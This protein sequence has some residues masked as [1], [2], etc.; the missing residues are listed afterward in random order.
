MDFSQYVMTAS[1]FTATTEGG[2]SA[3]WWVYLVA[4]SAFFLCMFGLQ[5]AAL[6][7]IAKREGYKHKW[8]AF[9]PFVSTYYIGVC[10][11]KNRLFKGLSTKVV[12]LV[13]AIMEAALFACSVVFYV[14]C[15][16]LSAAGSLTLEISA[17]YMPELNLGGVPAYLDWAE[18]CAIYLDQIVYWFDI[19]LSLFEIFLFAAFFQTYGARHYFWFTLLCV[20]FPVQGIIMFVVRKNK[21]TSYREYIRGEQERKYRMYRQYTE[22]D[23]NNNPYNQNP[24]SRNQYR[25][26]YGNQTP[27]EQQNNYHSAPED[28]FAEFGSDSG[29]PFDNSNDNFH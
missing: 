12:G 28:P 8:M 25:G 24:Y 19:V 20:L 3:Y 18:A 2:L 21:A 13:T 16:Q 10:S 29:D 11:Q 6:F 23:F 26:D 9:V 14:A 17:F 27:P 22:Q 15:F 1:Y 5:A 7:T 4:I